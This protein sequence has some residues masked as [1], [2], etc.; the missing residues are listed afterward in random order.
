MKRKGERATEEL[1]RNIGTLLNRV[2]TDLHMPE[3]EKAVVLSVL[4]AEAG[5]IRQRQ[6]VI[7]QRRHMKMKQVSVFVAALA[8]AAVIATA[9][10]WLVSSPQ[11]IVWADVVRNLN[12]ASSVSA[13]MTVDQRSENGK[14][15]WLV[16][17]SYN[18][19]PDRERVEIYALFEDG[20]PPEELSAQRIKEIRINS[21]IIDHGFTSIHLF[22]AQKRG[23]KTTAIF[24]GKT[25]GPSYV[26]ISDRYWRFVQ[27][28]TTD[29]TRRIGERLLNGVK[30]VGF[31]ASLSLM[32]EALG[33]PPADPAKGTIR[34][35]VNAANGLP[36]V[37]ES[38][39]G[40][41]SGRMS[42]ISLN[43][44]LPDSLFNDSA[45]SGY[46]MVENKTE[47]V[48]MTGASLKTGVSF[49]IAAP[50]K[51]PMVTSSDVVDIP[52]A[53][54]KSSSDQ[55]SALLVGLKLKTAAYARLVAF[56][57]QDSR[58]CAWIDLNNEFRIKF[59]GPGP[60]D[61]SDSSI[62]INLTSL[63]LS[64][65]QFMARYLQIPPQVK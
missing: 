55:S 44:Q 26:E 41:S 5:R 8:A 13:T 16:Y 9:I 56:Y 14:S 33:L 35:W 17:R 18:K 52:W 21:G 63:G 30:V 46:Q 57:K 61:K 32:E 58:P 29:Q 6:P 50:G 62:A 25:P 36:V 1:E 64:L 48:H 45:C 60:S 15:S 4:L 51:A 43:P 22:P 53:L 12:R 47:S 37:I 2:P 11:G 20:K 38:E 59:C 19:A 24:R 42:D 3:E 28:I 23:V 40:N 49:S 34:I 65:E 39:D 10:L 27:R 31:E 7:E 54:S